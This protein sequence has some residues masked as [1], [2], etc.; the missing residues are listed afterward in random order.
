[1]TMPASTCPGYRS[2]QATQR[3]AAIVASGTQQM[4]VLHA[5]LLRA[6]DVASTN[7]AQLLAPPSGALV[8]GRA[9]CCCSA[10]SRAAWPLRSSS[11]SKGQTQ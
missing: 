3:V 2:P 10:Y 11:G 7:L 6:A 9:S 4:G 5:H 8:A 1:M